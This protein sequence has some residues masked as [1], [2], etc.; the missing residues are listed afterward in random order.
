MSIYV[1]TTGSDITGDGSIINPYNTIGKALLESS[2]SGSI[3]KLLSGTYTITSTYMINKN[4]TITSSSNI[5]TDV[6]LS[7][8]CTIFNIVADVNIINISMTTTSNDPLIILGLNSDGTTLPSFYNNTISGCILTY[9]QYCMF[10]N[11]TFNVSNNQLSKGNST[12]SIPFTIY[13]SRGVCNLSTNTLTDTDLMYYFI[14]FS[15]TGNQSNT[16]YDM[17][18]SKAGRINIDN[19]SVTYGNFSSKFIYQDYYNQYI[20][21][22]SNDYNLNTKLT[23]YVNDNIFYSYNHNSVFIEYLLSSNSD[24]STINNVHIYNNSIAS[25]NYGILHL[26]KNT[27]SHTVLTISN[28][29]LLRNVFK[30][31]NNNNNTI[32]IGP[33]GV[34][35]STGLQGSTGTQGLQGPTGL[36]GTTGI[37]GSIGEQGIQGL[38]GPTGSTGLSITG[39]TGPQ[40]PTG[41]QGININYTGNT[42]PTGSNGITGPTGNYRGPTGPT[43]ANGVTGPTGP[44]GIVSSLNNV[45]YCYYNPSLRS[46]AI[47]YNSLT[48][49]SGTDNTAVGFYCMNSNLSGTGN[50][51]LGNYSLNSVT[52]GNYNTGGGVYTLYSL[53][54]GSYNTAIG[55]NALKWVNGSYNT[56]VGVNA[57]LL[58]ASG[59][60]LTNADNCT[61]FGGYSRASNN[62]V[63]NEVVIGPNAIGKGSNTVT[64][65]NNNILGWYST[66]SSITTYSDERD[67][68]ID[69]DYKINSFDIIEKLNPVTYEWDPRDK[70]SNKKGLKECGFIAQDILNGN[71]ATSEYIDLVDTTD[72]DNLKIK[73]DNMIPIII[74]CIKDLNYSY[75]YIEKILNIS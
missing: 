56:A 36:Q 45:K 60:N 4:V 33:T 51:A 44:T 54:S 18:N 34:Q 35:G 3:I 67:K 49:N 69:S 55:S 62:G 16:Y 28:S 53:T 9:I 58:I 2:L 38:Q 50:T 30:I 31:Y 20:N 72:I 10:L 65:G 63:T 23:M 70:G 68:I 7:S 17:C 42:G 29:D 43:G 46:V 47:G 57:G 25:S 32:T 24:I 39:P 5:N 1:S 15:K 22:N 41:T 66:N 61:Y 19:N 64:M 13:T 40:G 12:P 75:N 26:N 11:G 8:N 21:A 74:K 59:S 71:I 14:Y 52:T 73:K 27:S 37:Q 6:I 48:N